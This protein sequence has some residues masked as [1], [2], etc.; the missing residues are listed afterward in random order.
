[1]SEYTEQDL[2]DEIVVLHGELALAEDRFM[3][4]G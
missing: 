1:M 3:E 2:E 4:Q